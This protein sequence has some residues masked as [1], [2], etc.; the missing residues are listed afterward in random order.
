MVAVIVVPVHPRVVDFFGLDSV[1]QDGKE[2][3]FLEL[4]G[5]ASRERKSLRLYSRR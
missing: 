2:S 3:G 1:E 5:P 4:P